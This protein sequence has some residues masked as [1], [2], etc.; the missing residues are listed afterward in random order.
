[1][2]AP[3]QWIF[4]GLLMGITIAIWMAIRR[5]EVLIFTVTEVARKLE[6]AAGK[7]HDDLQEIA[8]NTAMTEQEKLDEDLDR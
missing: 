3:A 8:G 2:S 1:M 7:L 5:L 4:G 6:T